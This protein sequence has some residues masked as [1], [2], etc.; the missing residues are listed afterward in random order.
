MLAA[1]IA[2]WRLWRERA[3]AIR[4]SS[5]ATASESSRR[6]CARRRS[7]SRR[8]SSSCAFAARLMQEAVP[9]APAPWPP[10]SAWRMPQVEQACR[11]AAAGRGR[12]GRQFQRA[13]AG[14][15][16]RGERCGAARHRECQ[17]AR[18][19]AC[20]RA[21]RQRSLAQQ[22]DEQCGRQ[23]FGE[24]LADCRVRSPADRL[25]QR[26]R[27]RSRMPIPTTSALC[28]CG[29]WRARCAGSTPCAR[30]AAAGHLAADRMRP[31]QGAHRPQQA[32]RPRRHACN[33]C[34]ST[35]PPRSKPR[36]TATG[37]RAN[38]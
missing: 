11:E 25:H 13:G 9:P 23:R 10:S 28:W 7:I 32:H 4:P 21:A 5:R 12:G 8:P 19:Q 30:L 15:H 18:R 24:K 14:R 17:G 2:T 33:F 29:S 1:G 31:R 35:M 20:A 16:R 27:C 26:G 6:W 36:C 38:A 37:R 3:G 22:P 34:R